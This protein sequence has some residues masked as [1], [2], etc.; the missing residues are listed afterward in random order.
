VRATPDVNGDLLGRV[1]MGKV[2]SVTRQHMPSANEEWLLTEVGWVA[3]RLPTNPGEVF[4]DL[5]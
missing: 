3:R 2:L 5:S 4:G 1:M